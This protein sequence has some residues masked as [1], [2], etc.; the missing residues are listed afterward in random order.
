MNIVREREEE[1]GKGAVDLGWVKSHI[2]IHRNEMANGIARMGAEKGVDILQVI[3][4]GIWRRDRRLASGRKSSVL[5]SEADYN[6]FVRTARGYSSS[7]YRVCRLMMIMTSSPEVRVPKAPELTSCKCD[8][9]CYVYSLCLVSFHLSLCLSYILSL[10]LTLCALTMC[11]LAR[12]VT[13]PDS[14]SHMT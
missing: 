14:S 3:E 10:R 12:H 2:G 11:A 7:I 4:G 5:E 1:N 9:V 13:S 6:I 8:C